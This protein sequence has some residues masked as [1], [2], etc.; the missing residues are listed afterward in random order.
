MTAP[1]ALPSA[2]VTIVL[3]VPGTVFSLSLSPA[4]AIVNVVA[5]GIVSTSVFSLYVVSSGTKTCTLTSGCR[6]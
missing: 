3:A 1:C 2:E 5:V 4:L 6:L